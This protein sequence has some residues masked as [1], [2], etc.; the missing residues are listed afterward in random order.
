MYTCMCGG[1][2]RS[3]C[4]VGGWK[5]GFFFFCVSFHW[6]YACCPVRGPP[7]D[8]FALASDQSLRCMPATRNNLT[9]ILSGNSVSHVPCFQ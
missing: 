9:S 4:V 3:P 7:S 2:F 8:I 1:T 6:L 5:S